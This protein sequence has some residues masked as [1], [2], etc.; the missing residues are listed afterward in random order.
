MTDDGAARSGLPLRVR[1]AVF[2]RR[3][4]CW[5]GAKFIQFA[6]QFDGN[7]DRIRNKNNTFEATIPYLI[8]IKSLNYA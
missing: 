5:P 2:L 1:F 4:C 8:P 6:V 7:R 3:E